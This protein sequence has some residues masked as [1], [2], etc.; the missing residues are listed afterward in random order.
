[1]RL[2]L[3]LL[4]MLAACDP[5][6]VYIQCPP[7]GPCVEVK[8]VAQEPRG[9]EMPQ[10]L[11]TQGVSD[12]HGGHTFDEPTRVSIYPCTSEGECPGTAY[13]KMHV[14]MELVTVDSRK[15]DGF[16]KGHLHYD[17]TDLAVARAIG[18]ELIKAAKEATCK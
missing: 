9:K 10:Y 1:M 12:E 8:P 14:C 16:L 2:D 6:T 11:I 13:S 18:E 15:R 7:T 5:H 17:I 4:M 3:C